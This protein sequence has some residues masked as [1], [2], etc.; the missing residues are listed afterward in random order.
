MPIGEG[1]DAK[2]VIEASGS[3]ASPEKTAGAATNTTTNTTK[4]SSTL[5]HVPVRYLTS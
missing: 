4:M 2:I 5:D 1:I 3:Q